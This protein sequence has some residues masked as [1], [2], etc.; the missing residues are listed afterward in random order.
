MLFLGCSY[1]WGQSLHYYG[2]FEDDE[3]PKDGFYYG[4]KVLPHHYQYNVDNRFATIVADRFKRKPLVEAT[5][6]GSNDQMIIWGKGEIEKYGDDIDCVIMQT[7]SFA[8]GY[9]HGY[10]EQAQIQMILDFIEYC[11]SR[12]ILIRFVHWDWEENTMVDE[13]R[14]RT[15]LYDNKISFYHLTEGNGLGNFD[16]RTVSYLTYPKYKVHDSHFSKEGHIYMANIITQELLKLGYGEEPPLREP[17]LMVQK[18]LTNYI[19]YPIVK[20]FNE[21]HKSK[22]YKQVLLY[23]KDI[24]DKGAYDLD[25]SELNLLDLNDSSLRH[26]QEHKLIKMWM[27][28]YPPGTMVGFHEDGMINA[29]RYIFEYQPAD[30][31]YFEYIKGNKFH[32]IKELKNNLL[33]IGDMVH[34]FVNNSKTETRISIVFDTEIPIDILR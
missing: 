23:S 15:I 2:E 18:A 4:N 20:Y 24:T 9:D 26:L 21:N 13:V 29:Q 17:K 27:M 8:R 1:T 19:F 12:D 31:S 7:S 3:H 25:Y 5:N 33:F 34:Q 14:K 16:I 28:V 6:G 10:D 11:E 22:E 32:V 30:N